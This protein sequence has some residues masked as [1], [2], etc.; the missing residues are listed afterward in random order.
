MQALARV[1]FHVQPGDADSFCLAIRSGHV[2]PSVL[3]DRLVVLRDLVALGQVGIKIIL[4][5]KNRPLAHL[6]VDGQRGQRGELDGLRVE[7]RQRAGQSQANG[8][9]VGVRRRA[10]VIGA[11][12]KGLGGGQQLYVNF[13]SDHG[14]IL[15]QDI[16]GDRSCGHS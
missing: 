6:A 15:G 1:L 14:L 16:R 4:P 7:H 11:A 3:G 13:E 12:A 5:G 2:D 10:K 9:D 8:A